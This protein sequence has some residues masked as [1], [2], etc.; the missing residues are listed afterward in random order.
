MGG[1][2]HDSC[3]NTNKKIKIE[4]YWNIIIATAIM[5]V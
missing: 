1:N 4:V 3:T 2:I 5:L